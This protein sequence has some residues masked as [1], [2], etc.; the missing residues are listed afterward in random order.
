MHQLNL[1]TITTQEAFGGGGSETEEP[2]PKRTRASMPRPNYSN[3]MWWK[4]LREPG[5]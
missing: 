2:R 3:S 4:M 5:L 1:V